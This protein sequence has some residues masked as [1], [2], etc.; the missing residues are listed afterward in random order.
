MVKAITLYTTSNDAAD[1][2]STYSDRYK[3]FDFNG[4]TV[5]QTDQQQIKGSIDL[6][7]MVLELHL[8]EHQ[9]DNTQTSG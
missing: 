7:C 8:V 1:T 9:Q 3:S 2:G 5:G 6:C 4:F